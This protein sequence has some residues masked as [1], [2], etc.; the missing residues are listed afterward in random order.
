MTDKQTDKHIA[1][2]YRQTARDQARALKLLQA[3]AESGRSA[4]QTLLS[5]RYAPLAWNLAI[6]AF[7]VYAALETLPLIQ[8]YGWAVLASPEYLVNNIVSLALAIVLVQSVWVFS[9]GQWRKFK[10]RSAG[11]DVT[12]GEFRL[13]AAPDGLTIRLAKRTTAYKWTAF[14]DLVETEDSLLLLHSPRDG[15]VVP[16]STF[17]SDAD[18]Q[19]FRTFVRDHITAG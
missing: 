2:M 11:E 7:L 6:L 12:S 13:R 18:V 14:E 1:L 16:K 3:H 15:I 17:A 4:L 9:S 5:G 8:A 10:T 19:D